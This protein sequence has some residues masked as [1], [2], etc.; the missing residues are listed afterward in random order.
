MI[1]QI[2][3]FRHTCVNDCDSAHV[4][5]CVNSCNYKRMYMYIIV[6]IDMYMY[7]IL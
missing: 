7:I 3:L 1:N 4:N 6:T 5:I 2:L